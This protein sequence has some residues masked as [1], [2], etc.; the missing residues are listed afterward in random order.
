MEYLNPFELYNPTKPAG[1][2][3]YLWGLLYSLALFLIMLAIMVLAIP[4]E[5]IDIYGPIEIIGVLGVYIAGSLVAI[6]R[7]KDLGQSGWLIL[8]TFVP[9]VNLFMSL[10]LLFAPGIGTNSTVRE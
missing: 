10:W 1:R 9:L 7:L 5:Y 8:L 2:L 6:R 4:E 3:K